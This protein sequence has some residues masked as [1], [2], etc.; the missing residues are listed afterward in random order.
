M[1]EYKKPEIYVSV[2][3]EENI[4]TLSVG[5]VDHV[6]DDTAIA[7]LRGAERA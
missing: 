3:N 2:F 7:N 5:T 1:K 4:C 6:K